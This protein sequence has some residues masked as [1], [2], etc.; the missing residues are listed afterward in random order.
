MQNLMI[1]DNNIEFITKLVNNISTSITNINIYNISN[2]IDS[3]VL[4]II[5]KREVDIIVINVE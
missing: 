2:K 5:A 4:N 3:D 1:C